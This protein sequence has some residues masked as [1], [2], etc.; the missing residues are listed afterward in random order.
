MQK[1]VDSQGKEWVIE[2]NIA[3]AR[4]IRSEM[5]KDSRFDQYDFMDYAGILAGVNDV[6]FA[7]DL[8]YIVCCACNPDMGVTNTASD[9]RE[10]ATQYPRGSANWEPRLG[11]EEFGARL[12][13]K[14]L[15]DAIAAFVAE[16]LDFFPDP[17]VAEKMRAVVEATR[18]KQAALRDAIVATWTE[19][20][21]EA[22][23]AATERLKEV[24]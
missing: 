9:Q 22:L 17:T 3:T 18:E 2:L 20:V 16:Y 8:L 11:A 15:F 19:K 12:K 21:D 14:I 6:F 10:R 5:M 4:Q 23:T 7:A 24:H 13:G 1:F